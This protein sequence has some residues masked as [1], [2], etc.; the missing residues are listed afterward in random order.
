MHIPSLGFL[1]QHALI[2]GVYTMAYSTAGRSPAAQE[3][4]QAAAS[5]SV[6]NLAKIMF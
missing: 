1:E 2:N 6:A 5:T 4:G 3:E